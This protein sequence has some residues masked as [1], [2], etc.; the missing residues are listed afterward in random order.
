[1]TNWL[2]RRL[3]CFRFV[4]PGSAMKTTCSQVAI[5]VAVTT[6]LSSAAAGQA[7]P[8]AAKETM[9]GPEVFTYRQIGERSLKAYVF[10]PNVKHKGRAA[11]LLFHGGAWR[12]GEASWMFDRAKEFA[13]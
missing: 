10:F 13:E 9:G 1:M 8:S 4:F 3:N 5:V 7:P 11:V 12:L 2:Q 6:L